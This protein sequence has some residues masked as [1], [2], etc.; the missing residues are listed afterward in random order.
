ME[1]YSS[2]K[3]V[4]VHLEAAIEGRSRPA[5]GSGDEFLFPHAST[6]EGS[7]GTSK[8]HLRT[9]TD[10]VFV[11]NPSDDSDD[12]SLAA[13]STAERYYWKV[14]GQVTGPY[15]AMQLRKK[16][17]GPDDLVRAESSPDW[18][19]ASEVRGLM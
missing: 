8:S 15:T 6:G 16:K 18:C 14:M 9:G 17:I 1:R 13:P 11:P 19:R 3:D 12:F 2:M 7:Q 10:S 5:K 4:I